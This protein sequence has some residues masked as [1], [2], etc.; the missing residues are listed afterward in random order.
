MTLPVLAGQ[1]ANDCA[2]WFAIVQPS[3]DVALLR[4]DVTLFANVEGTQVPIVLAPELEI[5]VPPGGWTPS[6]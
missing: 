5:Q 4:L 1:L 6:P 2:R 3:T